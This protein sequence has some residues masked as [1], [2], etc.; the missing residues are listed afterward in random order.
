MGPAWT[1]RAVPSKLTG[2]EAVSCSPAGS[3]CWA[4]TPVA[5]QAVPVCAPFLNAENVKVKAM[6]AWLSPSLSMLI[7]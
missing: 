5:Y 4:S 6:S 3:G 2:R 1:G 7:R